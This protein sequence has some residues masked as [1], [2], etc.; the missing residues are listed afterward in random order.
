MLTKDRP[1]HSHK[2]IDYRSVFGEI[3]IRRA[4]YGETGVEGYCPLDARLNLPQ[5]KESYLLQEWALR[6]GLAQSYDETTGGLAELLGLS[7]P[8]R[9][10]ETVT[11][12]V[13]KAVREFYETGQAPKPKQEGPILVV[14]ADGKGVPMKRERP[15][16][17]PQRL[18]KGQKKHKKRMA[19][20]GG[21]YTSERHN[22]EE[23][24]P[25]V[26][27]K[28]VFAEIQ[29]REEFG[30]ELFERAE[31]REKGAK[32]KAFLGDGEEKIW[33]LQQEHFPDYE[34]ILDWM[35]AVEYLW[36]AAYLWL[37]ESSAQAHA[38]VERQKKRFRSGKV[39][40]V[41]RELRKLA[42]DGTI[43]GK[44]K[45]QKALTIANYWDRNGHRMRYHRYRRMGLPIGTGM[46]EG[47]GCRHLVRDRM[48][49]SGM[50]WSIVGAQAMLH[51]RGVYL[52]SHW[53]SF[54]EWYKKREAKRLYQ[55]APAA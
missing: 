52:S 7:I 1:F 15:Q 11:Q 25:E 30:Q 43:Q 35:H 23:D 24:P 53:E 40:L 48:E 51:V 50:R 3:A 6:M 26:L 14:Q 2:E 42:R 41:I 45:Q 22:G 19:K 49:R 12:E 8:K 4:Y 16:E 55:S 34:P 9:Q 29:K 33:E 27:H 10:I 32:R 36:K 5:R 54:W 38:W 18:S 17:A 21:V 46:V 39:R 31:R 13:G 28:E 20:V 37:P 47:G 44:Q